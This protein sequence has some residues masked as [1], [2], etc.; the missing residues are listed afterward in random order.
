MKTLTKLTFLLVTVL[1][2]SCSSS[3]NED[4]DEV[5]DIGNNNNGDGNNSGDESSI[6]GVTYSGDIAAIVTANCISCHGNPTSNGAPNSLTTAAQV[7]NAIETQGLIAEIESGSMPQNAG[8]LSN[9]QIETFKVWQ[10]E[11]F[12]D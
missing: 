10:E 1:F 5:I 2:I 4:T 11:G 6:S 7:K 12:K 3:A 8:K 9:D